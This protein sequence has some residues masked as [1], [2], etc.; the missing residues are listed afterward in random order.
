MEFKVYDGYKFSPL[1]HNDIGTE[2]LKCYGVMDGLKFD[3]ALQKQPP[4]ILSI[5]PLR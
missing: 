4:C 3:D 5:R 2:I 1:Q